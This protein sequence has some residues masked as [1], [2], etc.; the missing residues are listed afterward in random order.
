VLV[1]AVVL[2]TPYVGWN[3]W[4]PFAQGIGTDKIAV[5]LL[6]AGYNPKKDYLI[7]DRY[8]TVSDLSFYGPDQKH[9]CF[10][11]IHGLRQNQFCFWPGLEDGGSGY[12]ATIVQRS[13]RTHLKNHMKSLQK[14]LIPFFDHV[15]VPRIYWLTPWKAEACSGLIIIQVKGYH[16]DALDIKK[17][18]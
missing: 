8:Q 2:A 17:I 6:E 16:Q 14:K 3:S 18:F 4:S 9:A 11:N 13:E 1:Q 15:G 12:F 7:S 10:L 5:T